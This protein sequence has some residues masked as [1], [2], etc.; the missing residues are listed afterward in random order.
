MLKDVITLNQKR[1]EIIKSQID[2]LAT[3]LTDLQ[4]TCKAQELAL[5]E[6]DR[7]LIEEQSKHQDLRTQYEVLN[8]DKAS[9]V[10]Q[11]EAL[12]AQLESF[13]QQ[14]QEL[15]DALSDARTQ[16]NDLTST[17]KASFDGLSTKVEVKP[18]EELSDD[19]PESQQDEDEQ[20]SSDFQALNDETELEGE[21]LP[22]VT[23]QVGPASVKDEEDDAKAISSDESET[24]LVD[25]DVDADETEF[26]F[27]QFQKELQNESTSTDEEV[28]TDKQEDQTTSDDSEQNLLT[29]RDLEPE[30]DSSTISSQTDESFLDE[31]EAPKTEEAPSVINEAL[32]HLT[33]LHQSFEDE[34]ANADNVQSSLAKA[35]EFL[36]SLNIPNEL[37]AG[38]D[39]ERLLD[40]ESEPI[41]QLLGDDESTSVLDHIEDAVADAKE[42]IEQ[43]ASDISESFENFDASAEQTQSE[44][45]I[46]EEPKK[47]GF[48]NKIKS[49]VFGDK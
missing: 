8:L 47:K 37:E 25:E 24:E 20:D 16:I 45:T 5:K 39:V 34:S 42:K 18:E 14:H 7:Q 19:T 33:Q 6:M 11:N 17:M 38:K 36:Q 43:K 4:A 22:I 3:A 12:T 28:V 35:N 23:S 1:D 2:A 27:N 26:D 9:I 49:S 44:Q 10:E 29:E 13:T 31:P 40:S 46:E 15:L 48:F 41:K 21:I 30:D 32:E